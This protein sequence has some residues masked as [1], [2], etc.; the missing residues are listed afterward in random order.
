MLLH[1]NWH[2]LLFLHWEIPPTELQALLPPGLDLDTFE[3]KAYAGLVPFTITGVRPV[4]TPPLPW[5]S[6][7]HEVNVRTYV[8]RNGRDP[9]VWFFSLDASSS[10]AVA[11]ARAAYKLPYF[12]AEIAFTASNDPMPRVEFHS[13]R[14]DTRG[15]MPAN[16]RAAYQPAEG[17]ITHAAPGTLDHFLVERYIL[18]AV[19]AGHTLYRARVH[20]QPYPIQRVDLLDLDETLVWAAGIK[21]PE[22]APIRHYAREVN[23]K[24][25]PL[26]KC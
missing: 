10:I 3:G 18:Y 16:C 23:V 4:L 24:V 11:A 8:H 5:I 12:N 13:R 15:Q 26:E 21:R 22:S 6:S 14:E 17:A 9:G 1:Q 20:H 25:Y 2:H 7:F 19:D